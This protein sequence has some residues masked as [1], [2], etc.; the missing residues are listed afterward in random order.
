MF[1]L[2][3]SAISLLVVIAST[4]ANAQSSSLLRPEPR[5]VPV[6][7]QKVYVPNGFDSN[8]HVQLVG[9]GLFQH[10]CYRHAET[11]VRV[12][13]GLKK[14]FLG[15][16]AY[17]YQGLCLQMILPFE[18][19]ID[20]GVLTDGTWEIVQGPQEEKVG[21]VRIAMAT[22]QEADDYLYAPVSTATI[23]VTG[24]ATD[25]V[26]TGEFRNSCI[27]MDQVKLTMEPDVIV[28][29]PIAKMENRA[30]CQD[31]VFPFSERVS[32][33]KITPGRYLLHVRSMGGNALNS[34]VDVK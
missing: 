34:L 8:D 29:Q 14:V 26:L 33:P 3:A 20:V 13:A 15:P 2:F 18:R 22:K 24:G 32:L 5:Q 9:E 7:F 6:L 19:I 21:E 4:N 16:V 31:G 12:D 11:T 28:L 30:D 17:K 27:A 23:A 25:V 10:T 1:H